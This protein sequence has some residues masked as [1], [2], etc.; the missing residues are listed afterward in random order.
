MES[1]EGFVR[2]TLVQYEE[3]PSER[4]GQ[5]YRQW[6]ESLLNFAETKQ[7]R[8]AVTYAEQLRVYHV[9]LTVNEATRMKDAL[10]YLNRYFDKLDKGKRVI[11][12]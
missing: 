9:A 3:A 6:C 12:R 4:S 1:I 5:Q 10:A 2:R 8:D 11:T 7:N